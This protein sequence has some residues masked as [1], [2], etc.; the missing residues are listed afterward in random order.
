MLYFSEGQFELGPFLFSVQVT[1]HFA[2]DTLTV[3]LLK[4]ELNAFVVNQNCLYS[5]IDLG[6]FSKVKK[7][8]LMIINC[9]SA[10]SIDLK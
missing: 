7:S 6:S 8:R 9:L 5:F 2:D 3:V 4:I 1:S 10:L